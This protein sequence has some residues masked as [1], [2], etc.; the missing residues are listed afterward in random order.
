MSDNKAMKLVGHTVIAFIVWIIMD[1]FRDTILQLANI[2][3]QSINENGLQPYLGDIISA[4]PIVIA[5]IVLFEALFE[6]YEKL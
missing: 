6:L 1:A 4:I 5:L 2:D 3:L